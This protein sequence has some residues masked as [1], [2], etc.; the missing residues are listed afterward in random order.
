M[1]PVIGHIEG[2]AVGSHFRDRR[3]LRD[4]GIHRHL[5]AGIDYSKTA[6]TSVI[7]SGGYIDDY[8]SGDEIIYTG[9]GGNDP[10]TKR[11]MKDQEWV[12]GNAA[13]RRSQELRS[14]VRVTRGHKGEKA[15]APRSGYRYD[16][17]FLVR[18]AWTEQGVDGYQ[19]CRFHLVESN[20]LIEDNTTAFPGS[21]IEPSMPLSVPG[22]SAVSVRE[23]PQSDRS[24]PQS[25]GSI[26]DSEAV[27]S[28]LETPGVAQDWVAEL[29]ASPTFHQQRQVAGAS[30]PVARFQR[31][32]GWLDANGGRL[33][34]DEL[35]H[36]LEI[37]AR[38]VAGLVATA[39]R[40]LNVDGYEVLADDGSSARL[41]SRLARSQFGVS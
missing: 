15:Y 37:P 11:Q 39:R 1:E 38:R 28:L 18:E 17:L 8:D 22:T 32:L 16:G 25:V 31:L 13:L 12:R 6:A 3:D 40:V 27:Q 26:S 35:A 30:M 7:V 36:P 9:Q 2:V 21:P 34:Y 5:Q 10:S 23:G 19:I 14:P 20:H 41:D 29:V 4:A 24:G 33:T